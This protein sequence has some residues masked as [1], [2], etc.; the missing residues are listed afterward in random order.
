MYYDDTANNRKLP[1]E[2][3]ASGATVDDGGSLTL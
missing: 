3:M 1:A 2:V